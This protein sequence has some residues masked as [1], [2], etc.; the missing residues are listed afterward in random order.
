M[1]KEPHQTLARGARLR[2]ALIRFRR[3]EDGS[4]VV[5]GIIILVLMIMIGGIAVDVMRYEA[6]RTELQNTLDRSTLAAASLT[7]ELTP[8]D[9]VHDYFLKAGI[10]DSLRSV[11]VTQ[12]MNF[13]NV[14]ASAISDTDPL[15]LHMMEIDRLDAAGQSTAE[16]RINNV[17]IMLVLDV[18]GSM[19]NNSRLVNLKTAASDFVETVLSR[20]TENKISIGIVP[21]NGQVN[22]GDAL[23]AKF[24]ITD[25]NGVAS[26]RWCVDLP[27]S[28]YTEL[29]ISRTDALSQTANAD[30]YSG[31]STS[32]PSESNK[33][34]PLTGTVTYNDPNGVET[35]T[36][37]ANQVHLPIQNVEKLKAYINGMT[38]VG[39]TSINAGLKWGTALLDPSMR[40]VYG[41]FI[42]AGGT[43][44]ATLAGRPLDYNADDA[45][46][47]IVLMTDGEHFAEE[48]VKTDSNGVN[49]KTG[50]STIWRANDGRMSVFHASRVD[51]T[52]AT[53][54]ANSRPFYVMGVGWQSQP[55]TG[56]APP[57]GTPY[58]PAL[59][60][61]S[62]ATNWT[63]QT[64]W[65]TYGMQYV[66]RNFY[67][68]IV[69][70]YTSDW[71]NTFRGQTPT[72][73]M[74]DQLQAMCN[75][76]K[77]QNTL[78][79]GIAF[80]A[81]ANGQTQIRDCASSVAH[82]FNASGLQIS[83]AFNAIANN[84]SQLRLTQ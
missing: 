77:E 38:A 66:A 32:T 11:Q 52:N 71:T 15:F 8:T 60:T 12:G 36:F 67:A 84:I 44:P 83:S 6:R 69:G 68:N 31:S 63:W 22:L 39:A 20:D 75:L 16:Q 56:A 9:V 49:Y 82:Y 57:G 30:T 61:Y 29:S 62:G 14:D 55:W 53:T 70:G 43:V 45:M 18:S 25:Q 80:E 50:A 46:K 24:N 17:E 73:D 74:D 37:Y 4:L 78:I 47:V 27:A 48:R 64:V 72:G 34:C 41:D 7:Q 19:G 26:G 23:A 65:A 51:N 13:R 10:L 76:A 3:S 79:Y 40:S 21:F 35:E 5:F 58:V 2:H 59:T 33:W 1:S 54:I 42:T 28:T 81:P